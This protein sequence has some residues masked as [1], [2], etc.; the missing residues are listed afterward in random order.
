MPSM[1][2]SFCLRKM[3]IW[4]THRLQRRLLTLDM[5]L[6]QRHCQ[7]RNCMSQR[8]LCWR[9]VCKFYGR[10]QREACTF[11]GRRSGACW[12]VVRLRDW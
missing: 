8:P 2:R 10:T 6:H 7:Q 4:I 9:K 11:F 12:Q 5:Y 3:H 1:S